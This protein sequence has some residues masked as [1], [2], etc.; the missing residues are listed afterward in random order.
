MVPTSMAVGLLTN[1]TYPL[2]NAQARRPSAQ[3]V[4][5]IMQYG[6]RCNIVDIAN[7]LFFAY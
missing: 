2:D 1:K 6:I 7:Q 3:Y 4:H 5:I